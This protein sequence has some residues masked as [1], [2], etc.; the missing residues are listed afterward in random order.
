MADRCFYSF[1]DPLSSRCEIG[2]GNNLDHLDDS[3]SLYDSL[4]D[5]PETGISTPC[6]DFDLDCNGRSNASNLGACHQAFIAEN[7]RL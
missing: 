2:I 7:S 3:F 4:I 1:T 6:M 5:Y